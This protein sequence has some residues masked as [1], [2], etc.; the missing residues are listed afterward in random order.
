MS[1]S[2]IASLSFL[3]IAAGWL[4]L[5]PLLT[6]ISVARAPAIEAV[7][8]GVCPVL[9]VPLVRSIEEPLHRL[10]PDMYWPVVGWKDKTTGLDIETA[11]RK[12][13]PTLCS[14]VESKARSIKWKVRDGRLTPT[15]RVDYTAL[16]L[17]CL[18]PAAL[19]AGVGF[20]FGRSR[21]A[22]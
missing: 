1:P 12:E 8:E 22:T 4:V 21:A 6:T 18:L 10:G 16:L 2:K 3:S 17:L 9:Y 7:L 19:L 14:V 11:S 15:V 13:G 20:L 5:I